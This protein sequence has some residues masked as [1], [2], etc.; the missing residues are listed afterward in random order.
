LND[1]IAALSVDRGNLGLIVTKGDT[2]TVAIALPGGKF[3]RVVVGKEADPE[4]AIAALL[5]AA[6]NKCWCRF[7]LKDG[8]LS[9]RVYNQLRAL[10]TSGH[11]Q[12]VNPPGKEE[13]M[14]E[15]LWPAEA[16]VLV[17]ISRAALEKITVPTLLNLFGPILRE[18]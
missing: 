16:K 7:D 9:G 4:Q 3:E 2:D 15:M 17:V 6:K 12:I 1:F 11:L 10:G 13:N 8:E 14:V 18:E 5:A